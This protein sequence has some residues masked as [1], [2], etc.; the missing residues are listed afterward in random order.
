MD[1]TLE[2]ENIDYIP[3]QIKKMEALTSYKLKLTSAPETIK[4]G[5]PLTI[6]IKTEVVNN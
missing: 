6:P 4:L 3:V 2:K 5:M 1:W